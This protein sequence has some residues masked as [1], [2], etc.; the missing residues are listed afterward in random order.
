M[1]QGKFFEYSTYCPNQGNFADGHVG[2][3]D[4]ILLQD[5]G[6]HAK[7]ERFDVISLGIDE[8]HASINLVNFDG[9]KHD[10]CLSE[11]YELTFSIKKRWP[12]VAIPCV[13]EEKTEWRKGV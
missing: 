7:G 5:I 3:I 2:Y 8:N 1:V 6:E 4:C 11:V 13:E 9:I 12:E 10:I